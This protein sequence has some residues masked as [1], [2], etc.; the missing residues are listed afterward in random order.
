[1]KIIMTESTKKAVETSLNM[2]IDSM[3]DE[4]IIEAVRNNPNFAISFKEGG[5]VKIKRVLKG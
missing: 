1:M 4:A 2:N 3:S 5:E